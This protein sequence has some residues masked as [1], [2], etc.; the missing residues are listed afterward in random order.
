MNLEKDHLNA[1]L[2]FVTIS[3]DQQNIDKNLFKLNI[4]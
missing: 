2:I 4:Y 3:K 1:E